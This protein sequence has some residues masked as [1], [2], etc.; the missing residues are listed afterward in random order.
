MAV[1]SYEIP[2]V[3]TSVTISWD[4]FI[5]IYILQKKY[6]NLIHRK[7]TNYINRQ[8]GVVFLKMRSCNL[9]PY[10]SRRSA[11]RVPALTGHVLVLG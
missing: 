6:E 7:I 2:E 3:N 1:T 10:M 5:K 9:Q 8:S 11:S 4:F